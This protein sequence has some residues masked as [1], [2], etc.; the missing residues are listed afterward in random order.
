MIFV[1]SQGAN[2]VKS[3][4]EKETSTSK[5]LL[6]AGI[7]LAIVGAGLA[8]PMMIITKIK[9]NKQMKASKTAYKMT[10]LVVY[11]KEKKFKKE[12]KY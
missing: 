10:K 1:S 4:E 7:V 2:I 3:K 11:I 12:K 9:Y 6:I 8:I 5:G